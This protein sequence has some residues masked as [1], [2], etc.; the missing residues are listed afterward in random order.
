MDRHSGLQPRR[1][2]R[3]TRLMRMEDSLRQRVVGQ[4]R[5]IAAISRAIRR[6]RLGVSNPQRPVGSFIFLGPSGRRARPR[7]RAALAEFLFGTQGAL[8]RFDMSEYMEKHAVSQADRLAAGLRRPRGGRPAH[9]ARAP[10]ALL[11][12]AVRRDREGP[13]RRLQPAAADP[14]RRRAHRRLRQ[15]GRL[16]EHPGADDLEHRQQAGACAAAAWASAA[17]TRTRASGGSR[18]RSWASCDARSARSSSTASTR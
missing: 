6:S 17:A 14:R 12:G 11:A 7:W 5:A 8:L 3:P 16:Q 2:R 13:P 15:P 9:R 1:A 18:R 4:E 10:P